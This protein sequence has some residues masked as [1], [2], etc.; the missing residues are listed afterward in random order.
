MRNPKR[1]QPFP[2]L[3]AAARAIVQRFEFRPIQPF[4]KPPVFKPM[5]S[6]PRQ[7]RRPFSA[8]LTQGLWRIHNKISKGLSAEAEQQPPR[9]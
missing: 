1:S 2:Y 6:L 8:S 3:A 5:R 4:L 9:R 7:I